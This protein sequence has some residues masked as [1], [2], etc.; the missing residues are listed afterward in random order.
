MKYCPH[1]RV[2]GY[3]RLNCN[4][5]NI[6]PS[7]TNFTIS[8]NTLLSSTT[9]VTS[10]RYFKISIFSY[11]VESKVSVHIIKGWGVQL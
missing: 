2:Y 11:Y 3:L 9:V 8:L 7:E 5:R 10:D 4:L 6:L 1:N